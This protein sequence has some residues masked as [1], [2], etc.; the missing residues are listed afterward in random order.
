M[1]Q[2]KSPAT[3][4]SCWLYLTTNQISK[5]GTLDVWTP[6]GSGMTSC[7]MW[8]YEKKSVLVRKTDFFWT[9]K[10]DDLSFLNH[11]EFR[12]VM[13]LILKVWSVLK[14]NQQLK[15][16]AGLLPCVTPSWKKPFYSI[17]GLLY[18]FTCPSH[19][20]F[21]I[22]KHVEV[23]WPRPD[24]LGR[25]SRCLDVFKTRKR[26]IIHGEFFEIFEILFLFPV[27]C[28]LEPLQST[29]R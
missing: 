16:V 20:S 29:D 23:A 7:Q 28:V 26:E 6:S 11:W 21:F 1:T 27:F 24:S 22:S 13:C 3:P 12:H 17:K 9:F 10:F 2:G 4:L 8:K 14:W 18:R 19:P 5:W 25:E 15:G